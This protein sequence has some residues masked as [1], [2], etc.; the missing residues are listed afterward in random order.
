[1]SGSSVVVRVGKAKRPQS[2]VTID[3]K[4]YPNLKGVEDRLCDVLVY[5]DSTLDTLDTL[6]ETHRRLYSAPSEDESSSPLAQNL[7]L[8]FN[9]IMYALE[10]KHREVAHTR[11]K[12]EALLAKAQNTRALLSSTST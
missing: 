8:D 10:E 2:I 4:D 7:S 5:L 11:K 9:T 1:M 3:V 6:I 12:T